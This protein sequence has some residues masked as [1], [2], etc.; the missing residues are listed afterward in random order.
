MPVT[1]CDGN[2]GK[3]WK[4][5]LLN[6][7]KTRPILR[8]FA[9]TPLVLNRFH[10]PGP[11]RIRWHCRSRSYRFFERQWL[12]TKVAVLSDVV[13]ARLGYTAAHRKW[14]LRWRWLV[15]PTVCD[16]TP[17]PFVCRRRRSRSRISPKLTVSSSFR[18][19]C[20]VSQIPAFCLAHLLCRCGVPVIWQKYKRG[21][22]L[23]RWVGFFCYNPSEQAM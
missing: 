15:S 11:T 13:F 5:P 1:L 21:I 19:F 14:R 10:T 16:R 20:G 12:D 7:L 17:T 22:G 3:G 23:D 6:G 2:T 18:L 4:R 8:S 9:I